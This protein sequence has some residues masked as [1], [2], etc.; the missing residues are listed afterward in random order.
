MKPVVHIITTIS[1]GGAENQ[2]LTL[3]SEQVLEGRQVTIIFLKDLPELELEFERS[4]ARVEKFA[5]GLNPFRQVIKIRKFLRHRNVIVHAHLPRAELIAAVAIHNHSFIVSRHNAEK[6]FPKAPDFLSAWISRFVV[7]RAAF[8]IAISKAVA[9]F[10]LLKN[11]IR[12]LEKVRVVLYGIQ[13]ERILASRD[14]VTINSIMRI[15]TIAR[16]VPQKDYP[17]LLQSFALI[18]IKFPNCTLSILG[19]GPELGKMKNL[20]DSLGIQ[21]KVHWCGK[22]NEVDNFLQN[23]DL[24]VLTSIYEGFGLVLLEAMA[25]RTPI[26]AAN[27]SAIPEVIGQ[28]S[29]YLFETG[30][31]RELSEKIIENLSVSRRSEIVRIQSSRLCLFDS[32]TMSGNVNLIYSQANSSFKFQ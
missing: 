29:R 14:L 7:G 17:T 19:E 9:D 10:M 24:F 15:G 1:R 12:N 11:E 22:S 6:F 27:N 18:L 31:F 3:V 21:N 28:D 5:Y 32:R 30:N 13:K 20:A 23:L 4:G 25:N 26:I 8:C 2:L 16:I